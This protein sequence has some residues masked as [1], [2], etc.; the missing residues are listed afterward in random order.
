MREPN[1]ETERIGAVVVEAAFR[2]HR[3][4]GPGLLESA[5]ET[6]LAH[7]L[8]K[9]GEYVERQVAQPIHYGEITLDAGYRLDLLV[10]HRVIVELKA[11]EKLLPI[12]EAQLLTYLKLSGKELGFLINFN[13]AR[14][15]DGLNRRVF[16][17]EHSV[18]HRNDATNA[19]PRRWTRRPLSP[20]E[21]RLPHRRVVAVH[22]LLPQPEKTTPSRPSR[23]RGASSYHHD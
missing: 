11:V 12:H 16:T 10:G 6:C 20:E 17:Q 19:T 8:G 13:V 1:T 9:M 22:P 7:E 2:V 23:R 5:Y 14:L 18:V 21:R 15:K 3:E 4:L